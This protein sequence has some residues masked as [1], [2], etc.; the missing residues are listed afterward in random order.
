MIFARRKKTRLS[1]IKKCLSNITFGTNQLK[2][3]EFNVIFNKY[4]HRVRP[5]ELVAAMSKAHG[6]TDAFPGL[7]FDSRRN[8][9][10]V[11][12]CWA[13]KSLLASSRDYY[14]AFD[15]L[16]D[17]AELLYLSRFANELVTRPIRLILSNRNY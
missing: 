5:P 7:E 11:P 4:R 12:A 10:I 16:M 6:K 13:R 14:Y 3:F 15:Y 8:F 9:C 2:M 1:E 17:C